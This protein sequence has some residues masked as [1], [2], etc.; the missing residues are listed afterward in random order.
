MNALRS[1][2]HNAVWLAV[3]Q[4]AQLFAG[5]FVGLYVARYLGPEGYG[6]LGVSQGVLAVCAT[7]SA[8]GLNQI[9]MRDCATRPDL[10]DQVLSASIFLMAFAGL[11]IFL[12]AVAACAIANPIPPWLALSAIILAGLPFRAFDVF[13]WDLQA[14]SKARRAVPPRIAQVIFSSLARVAGVWRQQ[15]LSVFAVIAGVEPILGG[16]FV[17]AVHRRFASP[18]RYLLPTI[19]GILLLLRES[20]PLLL[21]SI[22]VV[23]YIKC[24][25]FMLLAMR[26]ETETGV[27][28]AA[29]RLSELWYFVPGVICTASYP[30]ILKLRENSSALYETCFNLRYDVLVLFS[31]VI[32]LGITFFAAPIVAMLL[33][34]GFSGSALVLQIHI[35]SLIPVCLGVASTQWLVA[36]KM[37]RIVTA[38][39]LIGLTLNIGLNFWLIP[40]YGAVGAAIATTLAYT[41]ST[42]AGL[43]VTRRSRS[44][45]VELTKSLLFIHILNAL[46]RK[47]PST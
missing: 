15:P 10:R 29:A 34:T 13:V 40:P 33:G 19:P 43:L 24:D 16:V 32:S 4:G 35:W 26:G 12:I 46:L 21:S 41:C 14:A 30:P 44:L 31:V 1:V 22:S 6:L 45:F 39:T 37:S 2:A 9:V 18:W 7:V 47:K 23:L 25:Q 17:K 38:R 20:W 27:Y 8:L 3:E 42:F 28:A 11:V 5:L 36:E